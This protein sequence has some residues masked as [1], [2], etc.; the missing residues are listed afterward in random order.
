[1]DYS[2]LLFANE[3]RRLAAELRN[4]AAEVH[5]NNSFLQGEER[6]LDKKKWLFDFP[7][8]KFVPTAIAEIQAIADMIKPI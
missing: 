1:M 2:E 8:M 5:Y 6:E 7:V 4:A 3:V